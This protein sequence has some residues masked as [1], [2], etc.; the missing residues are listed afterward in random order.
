M[1]GKNYDAH[2]VDVSENGV[3]VVSETLR[4]IWTNDRVEIFSAD[5]GWMT[6]SVR[7]RQ[8]GDFG[9]RLEESSN[10][11]AKFEAFRKNFVTA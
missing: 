8:P 9:V 4:D 11:R 10:T 1:G 6:G 3:H 7:W 5:L 2:I